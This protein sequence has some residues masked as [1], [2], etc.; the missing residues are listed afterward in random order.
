MLQSISHLCYRKSFSSNV[1]LVEPTTHP[2]ENKIK[3]KG[4]DPG[5]Y[6]NSQWNESKRIKGSSAVRSGG[7]CREPLDGRDG[8]MG[9][10][11]KKKRTNDVS[12]AKIWGFVWIYLYKWPSS[13]P[14]YHRLLISDVTCCLFFSEP[15]IVSEQIHLQFSVQSIPIHRHG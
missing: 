3:Q 15:A 14:Q 12:E 4:I 13:S 5:S 7:D 9:A 10:G 8:T 11:K 2:Y 6:A 1:T